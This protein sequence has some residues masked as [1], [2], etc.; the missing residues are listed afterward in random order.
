MSKKVKTL[1]GIG[2]VAVVLIGTF[3]ALYF[4]LPEKA[5]EDPG[6]LNNEHHVVFDETGKTLETITVEYGDEKYVVEQLDGST[7]GI[8]AIEDYVTDFSDFTYMFQSGN[9]IASYVKLDKPDSD[10]SLYGLDKPQAYITYQFKEGVSHKLIVGDINASANGYY[11][12]VDDSPEV[13]VLQNTTLDRYLVSQKSFIDMVIVPVIETSDKEEFPKYSYFEI[14]RPD[15]DKNI[16]IR[17]FKS[18]EIK[19]TVGYGSPV[20]MVSP[21][22]S[23]VLDD[24]IGEYLYGY[25]GL[26]AAKCAS[27]TYTESDAAKYGFDK[28]NAV[29][30]VKYDNTELVLTVGKFADKE[31]TQYYLHS[32]KNNELVYV[33]DASAKELNFM[34]VRP[35]Q[36]VSPV[37]VQPHVRDLNKITLQMKQGKVY[38]FDLKHSVGEDDKNILEVTCNGKKVDSEHFKRYLQ[39]LLYTSG[40]EI[41][42]GKPVDESQE[43]LKIQYDYVED[44]E[45]DVVKILKNSARYGVM[46]VNGAQN[47]TARLA[48]VD[49]LETELENLFAGK[50]IDTE[51]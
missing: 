6:I 19:T 37:A 51:W 38:T 40:E 31:K 15:L 23:L 42:E 25:F 49:K 11:T 10:L 12:M 47:F 36:L 22:E 3:L 16:Y 21:I 41:Y 45:P 50:P 5:E 13:Y 9:R 43:I 18:E 35:S 4:L 7:Y 26:T 29:L 20:K 30:R 2:V 14:E 34:K 39:L 27:F 44:F 24:A 32:S 8:A 1:I 28:P 48:Y 46:E 17:S 33:V